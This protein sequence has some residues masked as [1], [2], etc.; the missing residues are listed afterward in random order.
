M[1]DAPEGSPSDADRSS[2]RRRSRH[3]SP[4]QLEHFRELLLH[5]RDILVGDVQA[6]EEGAL[7]GSVQQ[8][9][10]KSSNPDDRGSE[11]FSQ[12]FSLQL[13]ASEREILEEIDQALKRIEE[14]TYGLCEETGKPISLA[15]RE[16]KPWA[17]LCIE[18]AQKRDRFRAF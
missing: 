12:D 16:A 7:R 11:A 4:K 3:L 5:R 13:A 2:K 18:A 1:I 17:R 14:G 10:H 15:R 6:L 9:A 8:G